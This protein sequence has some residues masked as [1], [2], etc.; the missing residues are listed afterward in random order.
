MLQ[1]RRILYN[2]N[3]AGFMYDSRFTI[4]FNLEDASKQ[5]ITFACPRGSDL[6]EFLS[7]YFA[8]YVSTG[9][10]DGLVQMTHLKRKPKHYNKVSKTSYIKLN[11]NHHCHEGFC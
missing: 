6:R 10:Y 11:Q 8:A 1:D 3:P 9:L 4:L 7:S 5:Q 2:G